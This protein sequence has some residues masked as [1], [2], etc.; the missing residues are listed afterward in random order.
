[1]I[2]ISSCCGDHNDSD[3][4]S[5]GEQQDSILDEPEEFDQRTIAKQTKRASS[6]GAST[7]G[8]GNA[9]TGPTGSGDANS[10]GSGD[11]TGSG[12]ANSTGSGDVH[13]AGS[14]DANSTGSGDANSTG[15]GDA[16]STG[17]GSIPN[18]GGSGDGAGTST[19][20]AANDKPQ[21]TSPVFSPEGFELS[22]EDIR[23]GKTQENFRKIGCK[24]KR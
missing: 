22:P 2:F 13:S 5:D 7:S 6:C 18:N 20:E 17:S 24:C 23:E 11:T 19:T 9:S 3:D 4:E 14:G 10:A 8:S 21:D 12:D 16:N 1:M 15:P